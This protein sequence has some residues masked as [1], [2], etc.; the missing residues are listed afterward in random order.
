MALAA[1]MAAGSLG[2]LDAVNTKAAVEDE[3]EFDKDTKTIVKYNGT[4]SNV[5][6]PSTIDGVNVTTIGEDAFSSN[7]YIETVE[8]PDSVTTIENE[9]FLNCP[10][11][12]YVEMSDNVKSL[13]RLSFFMCES[14][15][16]ISLSEGITE[17]KE[18]TFYGCSELDE[19]KLPD[20]LTAIG[21]HAFEECSDLET[22]KIPSNVTTIDNEAFKKCKS[23]KNVEIPDAVTRLGEGVFT[24]SNRVKVLCTENSAAYQYA[25]KNAVSVQVTKKQENTE[26][27]SYDITYVLNG[28]EFKGKVVESHD[29]SYNLRLPKPQRKGYTFEG[30]YSNSKLT[31]KVTILKKGTTGDKKFYAKWSKISLSRVKISSVQNNSSKSM[32]VKIK[33]VS[34]ADGYQLAYSTKLSMKSKK[35]VSFTGS[36]KTVKKLTKGKKYYV[37]VRAYKF[38]S[39]NKKVYGKYTLIPKS[40][41]IKK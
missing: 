34:K 38:D 24:D 3:F 16:D 33:K 36:S 40:V 29:G 26:K 28:G 35:L 4:Q 41:K 7:E 1:V 5:E 21:A 31:K 20:K 2:T 32:T 17:I 14:L 22:I 19:I 8:I 10:N 13:G 37:A 12:G 9:A 18:N 23:L 39:A 11:L 6:I 30:W 27:S 25:K 15:G